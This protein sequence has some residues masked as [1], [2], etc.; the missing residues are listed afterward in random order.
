MS[1]DVIERRMREY[2]RLN[3]KIY[4]F[5]EDLKNIKNIKGHTRE[6]KQLMLS[7]DGFD[8]Q[9]HNNIRRY[10]RRVKLRDATDEL[11]EM[12]KALNRERKLRE[13]LELKVK[14]ASES[15]GLFI[16]FVRNKLGI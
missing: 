15:S 10:E 3:H 1:D 16:K 14:E 6:F 5:K 13:D 8:E 7:L 9:I 12:Q 4:M 2:Y 11:K